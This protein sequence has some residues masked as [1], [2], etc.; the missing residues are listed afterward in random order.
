MFAESA[1]VSFRALPRA[2]CRVATASGKYTALF[3]LC[4][5]PDDLP[6]FDLVVALRKYLVIHIH[7]PIFWNFCAAIAK[8]VLL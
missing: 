4:V 8:I 1:T 5:M 2:L 6:L 3:P 7:T